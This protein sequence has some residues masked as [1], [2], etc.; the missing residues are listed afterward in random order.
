MVQ[1]DIVQTGFFRP[2]LDGLNEAGA[3]TDKLLISSGLNKFD[4]NDRDQY[5]PVH[6]MYSFFDELKRQEG[7][8]DVLD[9]FSDRIELASLSQWGEMIAYTPDLLTAAQTGVK[10]QGV[11]LSHEQAGFEINGSKAKY[12]HR[13]TDRD[14]NG[15]VQSDFIDFALLI[16]GVQLA[17]GKDWAPLEI[18]LQSKTAP[19]LDKLL[20]E[21]SNTE[22]FLG[23]AVSAVVFPVS[24]LNL[25]MLRNNV[26]QQ[27]VTDFS[28]VSTLTSK[29]ER[30]LNS[31][32]PHLILNI[33]LLAEMAG[34]SSRTLQRKLA[35][36]GTSLSEVIDQ[37]RFKQ[38][39]QLFENPEIRVQDV[40]QQLGYSNPPNF[41]RAFRRWTGFTPNQYREQL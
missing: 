37:W 39:I 13:F 7:I 32:Q 26:P 27:L 19:N 6:S 25:P 31:I 8:T 9:Q 20:P 1:L 23:Q 18:H 17:A 5:V 21:G 3:N 33:N 11:L 36:E 29:L 4:L 35:E 22:I 2:I 30:L 41:V 16:K 40:C 10:Y 15:R 34:V 28:P 24:L 12:W 14:C 38:A